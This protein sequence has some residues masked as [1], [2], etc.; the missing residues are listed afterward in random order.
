MAI[1]THVL[2]VGARFPVASC[3]GRLRLLRLGGTARP[4][5]DPGVGLH[6]LHLHP[7][8]MTMHR[9]SEQ[10]E[11]QARCGLTLHFR[12]CDTYSGDV[13]DSSTQNVQLQDENRNDSNQWVGPD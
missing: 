12:S 6:H 7:L 8:A 2:G 10:S 4:K 3:P 1:E 9:S 5:L 11:E 13:S